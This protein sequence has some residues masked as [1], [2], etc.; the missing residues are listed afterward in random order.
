MLRV[1]AMVPQKGTIHEDSAKC[2][3]PC[4]FDKFH[5]VSLFH[6]LTKRQGASCCMF[7]EFCQSS[8]GCFDFVTCS[9]TEEGR[10]MAESVGFLVI[11]NATVH[12]SN[13]HY[14][15]CS[16][17][18]LRKGWQMARG[19]CICHGTSSRG[20]QSLGQAKSISQIYMMFLKIYPGMF[21]TVRS[22]SWGSLNFS[23]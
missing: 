20:F 8:N 11:V 22:R 21:P 9:K 4:S 18:C 12:T 17:Q 6:H 16:N 14:I 19:L 3:A 13:D 7:E 1:E 23:S 5:I 10:R 15:C 2:L